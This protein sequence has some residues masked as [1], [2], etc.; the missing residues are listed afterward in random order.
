MVWNFVFPEIAKVNGA[1]LFILGAVIIGLS[2]W[3]LRTLL[4]NKKR[5]EN[6]T[7]PD[8]KILKCDVDRNVLAGIN[9]YGEKSFLINFL[10]NNGELIYLDIANCPHKADGENSLA[11]KISIHI[12]LWDWDDKKQL[13]KEF[14]G[15]W[16]IPESKDSIETGI[17]IPADR[18]GLRLGIAMREKG[19]NILWLLDSANAVITEDKL[20]LNKL[21]SLPSSC[22]NCVAVIDI[23][24]A[25]IEQDRYYFKILNDRNGK[26]GIEKL[27]DGEQWLKIAQKSSRDLWKN[28][29]K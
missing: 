9:L 21:S 25:N 22:E 10:R 23:L 8:I 13:Y 6:E 28:L 14:Y 4:I 5:K 3:Y 19:D 26:I 20:I 12:E 18:I 24:G 1:C 11:K 7:S 29:N 16:V 27:N 15:K 2:Y 17:D